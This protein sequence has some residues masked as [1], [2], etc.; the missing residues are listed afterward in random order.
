MSRRNARIGAP[1]VELDRG[2]AR[3]AKRAQLAIPERVRAGSAPDHLVEIAL[4]ECAANR[5]SIGRGS[6]TSVRGL[7]R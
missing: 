1:G 3:G 7:R 4:V 5:A 6:M 2:V